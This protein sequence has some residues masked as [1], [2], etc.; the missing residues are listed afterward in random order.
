[1]DETHAG[2]RALILRDFFRNH[3]WIAGL[4]ANYRHYVDLMHGL[5]GSRYRIVDPCSTLEECISLKRDYEYSVVDNNGNVICNIPAMTEG[6]YFVIQGEEKVL[7][8]QEVRLKSEPYVLDDPPSCECNIMGSYVPARII[9]EECSVIML[10]TSMIYK[11]LRDVKN[12]GIHPLLIKFFGSEL[13]YIYSLILNYSEDRQITDMCVLF[14]SSSA[15][16]ARGLQQR[17]A[18]VIRSKIFCGLPNHAVVM[19]VLS[20]IVECVKVMLGMS[21]VS[22]RDDYSVKRLRTPGDVVYNIFR[23]CVKEASLQ[24]AIRTS[25]YSCLRRGEVTVGKKKYDKMAVQLSKRSYIDAISSVRKLVR[26]QM[27]RV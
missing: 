12:I 8:I 10:D 9:I 7:L 15:T 18:E 23:S 26:H 19:T 20:M 6:G 27:A 21:S 17:D 16:G 4:P 24:S 3:G 22:D 25:V 5:L 2:S 14:I 13:G 1:M 11:D